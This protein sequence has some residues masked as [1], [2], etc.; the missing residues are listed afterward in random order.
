MSRGCREIISLGA[1]YE[2]ILQDTVYFTDYQGVRFVNLNA[3][4][5]DICPITEVAGGPEDCEERKKAWVLMQATWLDRLLAENPNDWTVVMAHQPVFSTGVSD[6]GLRDETDWRQ[7]VLPVLERH[8]VDLVLQG[9]DLT[10]GRGYHSSTATDTPGVSAGPVYVVSNAG[11]KMYTLP[12]ATDNIWTR[13][14][15]E[16][17]TREQDTATVQGISVD[18]T[19]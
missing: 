10:Y 6:N 2:Q 5:D 15:A 8:N 18:G 3:N 16:A 19:P 1:H 17:V 9:H 11:E 4:R 7:Q 13:N 14:G 12:S